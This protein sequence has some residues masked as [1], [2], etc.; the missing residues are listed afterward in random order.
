VATPI[1]D[2]ACQDG[3]YYSTP[4]VFVVWWPNNGSYHCKNL[5]SDNGGVYHYLRIHDADQ[6]TVFK[7]YEAGTLLGSVNVNFSRGE[8]FTNGE[9]HNAQDDTAVSHFKA[10]QKTIAG[11][12]TLYDFSNSVEIVVPPENNDP[13][14]HW[15]KVSDR[16]TLVEW[17]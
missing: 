14:F 4:E 3:P 12:T 8:D 1:R 11:T 5:L 6:D 9:R 15:S 16:E 10:L 7:Y 13:D 2:R 17:D